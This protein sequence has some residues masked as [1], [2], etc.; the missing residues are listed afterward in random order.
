MATPRLGTRGS[1]L[2]LW[3]TSSVR[4]A[5]GRAGHATEIVTVATTGDRRPTVPLD[6]LGLVDAF[7]DELDDALLEGRIDLAVHSLKD[8]PTR[9][10]PGTEIAAIGRRADPRDALVGRGP[11]DLDSLPL[12]GVVATCSVRRRAQLLRLRPDLAVVPLRGNVD[13]RVRTLDR[14]RDWSAILLA[15]AGLERLALSARIGERIDPDLI[16]P[17]PGQGAIAVTVRA[18]DHALARRVRRAFHHGDS[19][20]AVA[21]ERAV[22]DRLDAACRYPVAALAT[23]ANG[24]LRLAA[25]VVALDASEQL[26]V[27]V[28]GSARTLPDAVRL[29]D[30]AA[31]RLLDQGAARLLATELAESGARS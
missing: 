3:Q 18:G 10:A 20:L 7:T 13:G 16:M 30:R 26:D 22:L 12:R 9:L 27:R 24:R 29:G 8:L 4:A 23:L 14:R 2:A 28:V 5:L 1:R 25:R 6:R 17:A 21:A 15:V 11:L 19:A 31:D